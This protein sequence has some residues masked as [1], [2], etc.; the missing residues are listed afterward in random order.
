MCLVSCFNSVA[1]N[2]FLKAG[3]ANVVAT[4]GPLRLRSFLLA[5]NFGTQEKT[6]RA[7]SSPAAAMPCRGKCGFL[8][9]RRQGTQDTL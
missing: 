6:S 8:L 1:A 2:A 7:A 9:M 3:R 5:A 4:T